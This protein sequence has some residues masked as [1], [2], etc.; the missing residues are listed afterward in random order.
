MI[1]TYNITPVPKPRMTQRDK[2]SRRAPVLRYRAFADECRKLGVFVPECNYHVTFI[3]PMA[4]TWTK[5]KKALMNGKPHQQ[6]PDKDN[7]E[8]AL[9][10]A[11]HKQDCAVWDGRATK[12]W[13]EVGMIIIEDGIK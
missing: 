6:T 13:G 2:W 12:L 7:L 11:V 8:K 3:L 9:L 10:D 4:A 1:K 5:K